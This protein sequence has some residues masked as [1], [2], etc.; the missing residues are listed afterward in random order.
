MRVESSWPLCPPCLCGSVPLSFPHSR[1]GLNDRTFLM[2]GL[3]GVVAWDDR[4]RV[5]RETLARMS[6]RIAHRGR[7]GEGLYLNHEQQVTDDH[8]QVGLVHRRLAILDP[9]PRADQPFTGGRGR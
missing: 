5:D 1:R 2:C 8:P 6:A 9:D 4:F 7:D 3:A